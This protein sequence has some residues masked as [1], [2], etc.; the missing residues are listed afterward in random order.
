MTIFPIF[1][2]ERKI[3]DK[4][5]EIQLPKKHFVYWDVAQKNFFDSFHD[6]LR[7]T[8]DHGVKIQSPVRIGKLVFNSLYISQ[9]FSI[10]SY[11][12]ISSFYTQYH[13]MDS[14]D[15]LIDLV[16]LFESQ[17]GILKKSYYGREKNDFLVSPIGTRQITA[18][19]I[20]Y[21]DGELELIKIVMQYGD[22]EIV[23]S[24][25]VYTGGGFLSLIF[26]NSKNI[27]KFF[28]KYYLKYMQPVQHIILNEERLSLVG[29]GYSNV[30]DYLVKLRF[31]TDSSVMIW[32]DDVNACVGFIE[33]R[34]VHI[35]D[36]NEISFFSIT[37]TDD[38]RIGYYSELKVH[39]N[40]KNRDPMC[41]LSYSGVPGKVNFFDDKIKIIKCIV[42]KKIMYK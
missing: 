26:W 29:C 11:K 9:G 35:F 27:S 28:E 13:S 10:N 41:L 37:N 23:L 39:F 7:N 5:F 31:K 20:N 30:K 19:S 33:Q 17:G 14:T 25:E 1:T 18:P 3:S 42:K 22:M 24:K 38:G 34:Q 4:G 2:N 8:G 15:L 16:S 36:L 40:I 12:P 6:V 21:A 32:R